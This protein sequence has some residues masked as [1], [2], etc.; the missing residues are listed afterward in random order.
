MPWARSEKC[1]GRLR[2]VKPRLGGAAPRLA[3]AP[4]VAESFYTSREWRALTQARKRDWDYF[5]A[6]ARRKFR[7]ERLV[8]D[9]I[10][11]RRD[12]GG[13][14]DPANT[15]WLTF[16]EHQAKTAKAKAERTQRR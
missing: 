11:E 9:H 12:G 7:G 10:V 4:K 8:L 1:V 2:S 14:L 13:D 3:A 5:A 6:M 15:Q 16:G